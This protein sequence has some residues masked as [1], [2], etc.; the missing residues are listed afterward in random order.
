MSNQQQG[1]NKRYTHQGLVR[2]GDGVITS[3]RMEA[4]LAPNSPTQPSH[5]SGGALS[6]YSH[7]HFCGG[8]TDVELAPAKFP[9]FAR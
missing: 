3:G 4:F 5:G 7:K 1:H 8:D 2:Q 6:G 9:E